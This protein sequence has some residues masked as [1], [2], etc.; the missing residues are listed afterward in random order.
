MNWSEERERENNSSSRSPGVFLWAKVNRS[1]IRD[2]LISKNSMWTRVR[3]YSAPVRRVE[4]REWRRLTNSK[5]YR[6]LSERS[7]ARVVDEEYLGCCPENFF[8]ELFSVCLS[9]CCCWSSLG[10][11]TEKDRVL[12]SSSRLTI[13]LIDSV[14]F[15]CSNI[16][17][18]VHSLFPRLPINDSPHVC[19]WS[20]SSSLLELNFEWILLLR[21]RLICPQRILFF[22]FGLWLQFGSFSSWPLSSGQPGI[23]SFSMFTSIETIRRRVRSSSKHSLWSIF[24]FVSFSLR[25]NCIKQRSVRR[26]R[27]RS[28]RLNS[29]L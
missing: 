9:V 14:S 2:E 24:S 23:F 4:T 6:C 21:R 1:S 29:S 16:T 28:C 25:W 5:S 3:I 27:R 13:I 18:H 12:P 19:R 20:S 15:F 8:D 26:R 7:F 17:H 10:W 22:I 11:E